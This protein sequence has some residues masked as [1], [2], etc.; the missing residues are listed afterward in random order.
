MGSRQSTANPDGQP[1]LQR[2]ISRLFSRSANSQSIVVRHAEEDPTNTHV[3]NENN[4]AAAA[5]VGVAT[6]PASA[7]PLPGLESIPIPAP[8]PF[9]RLLSSTL[10]RVGL[11]TNSAQQPVKTL[12]DSA[13]IAAAIKSSFANTPNPPL[14]EAY[15]QVRFSFFFLLLLLLL[16]SK[17]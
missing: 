13:D 10:E 16:R 17:Y 6:T 14:K 3:A 2:R 15:S 11:S 4:G 8:S 1:S 9:R 5:P 12:A 7:R